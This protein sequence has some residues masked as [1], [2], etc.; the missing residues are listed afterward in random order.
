MAVV[1]A[2]KGSGGADRQAG[3]NAGV[4]GWS[5]RNLVISRSQDFH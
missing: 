3:K 4:S 2:S 5:A 1:S